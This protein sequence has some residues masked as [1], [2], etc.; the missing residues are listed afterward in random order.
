MN[1]VAQKQSMDP[2]Q[3][4]LRLLKKEWNKEVSAFID[5]LIH[6]K[7]LV[8]G[9]PN[10]F[11]KEKS[12]I[13]NPIP[14]D[15]V[16]IISTLANDFQELTQRG[17]SIIVAQNE[18]SKNRKKT[19]QLSL[20]FSKPNEEKTDLTKQLSAA[21]D[22]YYLISEASN[23]VSR[24]FTRL[25]NPAMG[26]GSGADIR[27]ARIAMLNSAAA[28]YKK[29]EKFQ[30]DIVKSS[31][32]SILE[33]NKKLREIWNSWSLVSRAF[34]IYKNSKSISAPDKGGEVAKPEVKPVPEKTTIDKPV[35]KPGEDSP[36]EKIAQD[37]LRKWVGK[38][39]HQLSMFDK[40]S[41]YRLSC[42][43]LADEMRKDIDKVMDLLE[44]GLDESQLDYSIKK[45]N[46]DMTSLRGM[47][48]A[49][50]AAVPKSKD[51]PNDLGWDFG[52]M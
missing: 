36:V 10:K 31:N 49:L 25:F 50:N 7:K 28:T 3:Q 52:M 40:T 5:N 9:H 21:I 16:T 38:T 1:K 39:N 13:K 42:Y 32:S 26:F 46:N 44:K 17:N 19:K 48:R 43:K 11:F 22:N 8:N 2:V 27:R 30:V 20:D 23:P 4:K 37:F 45:I 24:F 14:A 6:Y 47:M 51:A 34:S 35:E 41:S 33:S 29:L 12:Y 15:P 18:Y